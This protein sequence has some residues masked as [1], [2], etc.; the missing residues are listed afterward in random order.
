MA[1]E[2]PARPA[3]G[4]PTAGAANLY[5]LL[6]L[7]G[8]VLASL[9]QLRWG[10]AALPAAHL[11]LFV[12]L[13]LLFV[14]A[15]ARREVFRLRPVGAVTL[16]QS[17]VLGGLAWLV[18]QA[19]AAATLFAI[20]R[21]GGHPL[22]PYERLLETGAPAWAL[23]LLMAAMP[24]FTE[25][26]AYRGLVLSGYARLGGRAAWVGA[27]LLF[28]ALH[29]S[30]VQLPSLAALGMVYSYAALRTGS[31][32]PGAVMHLTNNTI[33]LLLML[34]A[35]RDLAA[36]G[37]PM[38]VGALLYWLLAGLG[39]LVPLVALLRTLVPG[40]DAPAPPDPDPAP[41][42]WW[43]LLPALVLVLT[44]LYWEAGRIFS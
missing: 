21:L 31:L 3:A 19:L 27:G 35:P 23:L 9:V 40:P 12:L 29:L 20:T 25:E 34:A 1:H 22:N 15:G 33:S 16:A 26:F 43:P 38:P 14:P 8:A 6:C 24:A 13:P 7:L 11:V 41:S 39:A 17:L 42:R 44:L 32:L 18:A 4:W 30:V 37:G 28:A 2:N 36:P 5:F 10:P